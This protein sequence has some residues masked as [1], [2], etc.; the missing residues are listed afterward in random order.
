MERLQEQC[1]QEQLTG[2]VQTAAAHWSGTNSSGSLEQYKQQWFTARRC[3]CFT[4]PPSALC[5]SSPSSALS[6]C[7]ISTAALLGGDARRKEPWLL[8]RPCSMQLLMARQW[9]R[10]VSL[11]FVSSC[12]WLT[13]PGERAFAT[14][15]CWDGGEVG[16][17]ALPLPSAMTLCGSCAAYLRSNAAAIAVVA[18]MHEQATQES[19]K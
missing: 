9:S 14:A 7:R 2:A 15:D 8:T 1:Q 4:V 17:A 18:G 12:C 3:L 16:A 6:A 5:H 13:P 10:H 11:R 19:A